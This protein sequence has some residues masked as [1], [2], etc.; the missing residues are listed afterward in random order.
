[1][2]QKRTTSSAYL[3][4][5]RGEVLFAKGVLLVE[6][7][8]EEYMVP[9]LAELNGYNLDELGISVC[10]VA[11]THFLPYLKFL[12]PSGL[13]IPC[14]VITDADPNVR[15]P[16][17]PRIRKLLEY[18][19]PDDLDGLTADDEVIDLG[20]QHGL[21][22]TDDT[23]EVALFRSGRHPSFARTMSQLSSGAPARGRANAWK[24][25]PSSLDVNRMLAD[26]E[27]IGKGRFS[28][29]W[30]LHVSRSNCKHCPAS[31]REALE[32]VANRI[33][34]RT[35]PGGSRGASPES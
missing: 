33:Q 31:V 20:K 16:G 13:N 7:E 19:A 10:S 30:A 21:F 26:I 5:T 23:F 25:N 11:G 12:G 34:S 18:L 28:Q 27:A 32:Y 4:V 6:G 17:L 29:R 1:M 14:A 15:T 22:L 35:V 2:R 24:A 8:A 3:D 9:V